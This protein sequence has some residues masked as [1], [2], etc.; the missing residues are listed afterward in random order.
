MPNF[1]WLI[2]LWLLI[3]RI[4]SGKFLIPTKKK[5]KF[6]RFFDS[7]QVLDQKFFNIID[8]YFSGK[9]V[10]WW[11][12]RTEYMLQETNVYLFY[13]ENFHSFL[14]RSMV[15]TD[16]VKTKAR[17][18]EGENSKESKHLLHSWANSIPWGWFF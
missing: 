18:N 14:V 1:Y 12:N 3:I 7:W 2:K 5:T 10:S 11:W 15:P 4:S 13:E 9:Q 8:R 17:C 16:Q 6:D